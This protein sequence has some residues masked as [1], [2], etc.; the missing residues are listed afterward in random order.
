VPPLGTIATMVSDGHRF[1]LYDLRKKRYYH[2]TATPENLSR[3]LPLRLRGEEIAQLLLGEP[4][5]VA[6]AP[7]SMKLDRCKSHYELV[8]EDA[9]KQARQRVLVDARLLVPLRSEI[10][11]AGRVVYDVSFGDHRRVAGVLVPHRV[12]YHAPQDEVDMLLTYS[13]VVLNETFEDASF[14]L[15]P[16]RGVEIVPLQ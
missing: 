2:G 9:S 16:Q 6:K 5:L 8:F 10:R 1:A 12:R 14:R 11:V 4:P 7:T 15:E 3:L 13:D